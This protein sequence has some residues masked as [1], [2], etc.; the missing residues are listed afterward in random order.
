MP[1]A[2]TAATAAILKQRICILDVMRLNGLDESF[3]WLR[4]R[5]FGL[6]QHQPGGRLDPLEQLL[7]HVRQDLLG[8]GAAQCIELAGAA[9][10]A[11]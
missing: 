4:L 8:E 7:V 1:A 9:L 6:V 2:A 11:A 3:P 10:R 5:S